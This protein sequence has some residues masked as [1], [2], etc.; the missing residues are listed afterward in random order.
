[1]FS[2]NPINVSRTRMQMP[3]HLEALVT[4]RFKPE[5][6]FSE[7]VIA[8]R[9][10]KRREK[11]AQIEAEQRTAREHRERQDRRRQQIAKILE[12][13]ER[14]K[15]ESAEA[16]AIPAYMLH[17]DRPN[18]LVKLFSESSGFTVYE[19]KSPRR[20]KRL[21]Q[22]RQ[23]LAWLLKQQTSF[24]YPRI[25]RKLG[26]RDHST[27]IHSIKTVET[28][29]ELFETANKLMA[30]VLEMEAEIYGQNQS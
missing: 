10:A 7:A 11:L 19:L 29:P 17:I 14:K 25:G 30:H 15:R 12:A 28:K 9:E 21:V 2:P 4:K 16:E 23:C 8:E 20:Q 6:Q 3:A 26:D 27:I 1:M 22:A 5:N 24:S 18:R 13:V